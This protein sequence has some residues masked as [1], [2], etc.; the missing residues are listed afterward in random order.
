MVVNMFR[1]DIHQVNFYPKKISKNL[2]KYP[3]I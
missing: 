3:K 1:K 2:T